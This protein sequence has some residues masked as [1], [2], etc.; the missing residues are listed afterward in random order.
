MT[1]LAFLVVAALF[2]A[3]IT[4]LRTKKGREKLRRLEAG[5]M[6]IHCSGT[7]VERTDRGIRCLTCGQI[8]T[9]ALLSAPS[10]TD[11]EIKKMNSPDTRRP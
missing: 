7:D 6:C 8:T 3:G 9:W 2:V 5:E 11:A 4:A 10:P 1:K